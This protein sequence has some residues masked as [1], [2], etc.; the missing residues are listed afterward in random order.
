[1]N[2]QVMKLRDFFPGIP[3]DD[4]FEPTL[5][6][7]CHDNTP[8]IDA[9]RRRPA[10]VICPGGG[11]SFTSDREAEPVALAFLPRGYNCFVLR[12]SCAP[13][14]YP[15]AL[16]E[17]SAAVALVR[18]KAGEFQVD[19]AKIAV[20]GFSAGGHLAASLGTMWNEPFI[21]ERLGIPQGMN[22]PDAMILGYPVIT[23]GE[24]A[25]R[26]SFTKLL[27]EGASK[28]EVERVSLEN[29]VHGDVPPA[30]IWHTFDDDLVPVE[31]SL[32]FASALRANNI[33]FE[34]HIYASGPHGLSLCNRE[35]VGEGQ[36][37]NPHCATWVE[38]CEQWLKHTFAV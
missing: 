32:L 20:C 7:Y 8:E 5:T 29:R 13:A 2:C 19:T 16:L 12:Y 21:G 3:A 27:G 9:R 6:C 23:S 25:H 33:P 22:R 4:G 31:N 10:I 30:F 38:L 1:M 14:R 11:Y 17:V 15:A 34:L 37:I 28:E 26:D 24:K 35:S 18:Q 36:M